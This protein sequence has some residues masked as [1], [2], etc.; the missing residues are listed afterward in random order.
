MN[1]DFRHQRGRLLAAVILLAAF[2]MM[3]V[4]V[5]ESSEP[6]RPL[7]SAP[8]RALVVTGGHD[9]ETSFYTVFEGYDDLTWAHAVSNQAAFKSDIRMKYDVLVLYDYTQVL[10]DAG[11]RNLRD[12]VESGKG[13]VV[14]HHAICSYQDWDW[15]T[16]DVV[17]GKYLLKPEGSMPASTYKHDEELAVT[18]AR[19]HPIVDPIGVF[20][21]RDETY[22]GKWIS[23]DNMV[24]MT[25][26]NPTADPPVV[27]ISSYPKSRVVYV[28]LGHDGAAFRNP[29]FRALVRNSMFWSAGRL[30]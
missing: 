4:L 26:D 23:P 5:G 2:P 3:R 14:M 25:T 21:I 7:Q 11:R 15:W 27:W 6:V 30:K 24:L 8:L 29:S 28:A 16:H 20:R 19:R 18:P 9:Y 12:Y 13:V 17:G 10:D 1:W 22:K